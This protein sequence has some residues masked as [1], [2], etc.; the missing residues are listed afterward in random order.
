MKNPYSIHAEAASE[1]SIQGRALA[2]GLPDDLPEVIMW[3]PGGTHTITARRGSRP[4]T[5]SVLVDRHT[6]AAAQQSL[7][8]YMAASRQK[9]CFDFNHDEKE[10]A[11][12]PM[13]FFWSEAPEPGVYARVQWSDAGRS[14][15][16]GRRYR[17]FSPTFDVDFAKNPAPIKARKLT[18]M[19]ALTND[20]AFRDIRPLWAKHAGAQSSTN[21]NQDHTHRMTPEQIAAL[22]AKLAEMEQE[23]AALKAQAAT[24]ESA[25]AL[26]AKEAQ[27]TQAIQ[28]KQ[29][30]VDAIKAQLA[31]AQQAITAAR[32]K[33][34]E[35]AVKAAVA[36]GALPPKDEAIQA[37][38]RSLIEADPSNTV[39]LAS[40]PG[41]A[42]LH[43]APIV[44]RGNPEIAQEGMVSVLRAY[45]AEQ[46]PR[47][48]GV[49]YAKEMAPL[50]AKGMHFGDLPIEASNVPGTI[51]GT[52]V[53]QRTLELCRFHFPI[54][55][56]ICT[57]FSNEP[58]NYGDSIVTRYIGAPTPG[59]YNT[60]TGYASQ[61]VAGTD[62]TVTINQH[63]HVQMVFTANDLAGG[64]RRLFDE[65]APAYSYAL[66]KVMVDALY[67]LIVTGTFTN[68]VISSS[69]S[70]FARD[71]VV[72]TAAAL[73]AL[74]VPVAN[75]T[76]LLNTSLYAAL[77][78]DA[79]IVT[80]AAFQQPGIITAGQLPDVHGFRV[81]E[82]PNLPTTSSL[83]G[84]GM[85]KDGLVLATR[86]PND[87]ASVFPGAAS[88]LVDTVTDAET[89][90]SAMQVRY[91][92]HTLGMSYLRLAVMYGVVAGDPKCGQIVTA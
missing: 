88:G 61:D 38:W 31:S 18:F 29:A 60:S 19:G 50:F 15:I 44:P 54:L 13:E 10:A 1:P 35:L 89:G 9:P 76:L 8:E 59:T 86:L 4:V 5:V 71:T 34:A 81:V 27:H 62:V 92:D 66:S 75:R 47:Q 26:K 58:V 49:I 57:D 84:F 74:G 48:R 17:S 28:A 80:L 46:N 63:K 53:S 33:D 7:D 23:N 87:Y 25:E 20:P 14:A 82:A 37:K 41:N 11:G 67:A 3:M 70:N 16:Q 21:K 2:T 64:R 40:L 72:D 22:Q 32:Q 6:A 85:S 51:V 83:A 91:V 24:A 42:A 45:H 79:N 65:F 77:A 69:A 68:T 43:Q 36:R 12:W 52:L 30:E 73:N 55:Q 78:K 56:R 39:L 90:M